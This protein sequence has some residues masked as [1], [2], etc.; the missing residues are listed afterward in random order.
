MRAAVLLIVL[1]EVFV[2]IDPQLNHQSSVVCG[3][4]FDG[5]ETFLSVLAVPGIG[6]LG[7]KL[8][9]FW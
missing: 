8:G 9:L 4:Y 5:K 6:A 3:N 1:L 2:S 7:S